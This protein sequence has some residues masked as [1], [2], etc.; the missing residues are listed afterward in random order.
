MVGGHRFDKN[1]L[2][3]NLITSCCLYYTNPIVLFVYW[4]NEILYKRLNIAIF[5]NVDDI[6]PRQKEVYLSKIM[7]ILSTAS[8]IIRSCERNRN[9]PHSRRHAP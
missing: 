2:R 4:L 7:L 9:A 6:I 5:F 3:L 8:A 1:K